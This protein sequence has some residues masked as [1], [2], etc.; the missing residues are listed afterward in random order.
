M[1]AVNSALKNNPFE[2][3]V[4]DD[5]SSDNT[6]E[7]FI[8]R[9]KRVKYVLNPKNLGVNHARNRLAELARGTYLLFLDS[10]DFLSECAFDKINKQKLGLVNFFGTRDFSTGLPMCW[11]DIGKTRYK[12]EDWL[13][14]ELGGEFCGVYHKSIFKA[15]MFD[16]S[17]FC[18]ES[19]WANRVIRMF[20]VRCFPDTIRLYTT[21]QTNRVSRQMLDWNKLK[22]R[23]IDYEKYYWEFSSDLV[24]YKLT[25]QLLILM[26][27]VAAYKI[28]SG[29]FSLKRWKK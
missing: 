18:F 25:K 3:I 10:D 4:Y 27:K 11:S 13:R 23:A 29:N 15:A 14:G 20:G 21:D 16:E 1:K 12:Y 22:Q 2:V 6:W 9:D 5:G 8:K 26:F 24:K 7:L 19:H 28:V 17:M